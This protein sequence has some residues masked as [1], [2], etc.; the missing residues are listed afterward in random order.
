MTLRFITFIMAL[1]YVMFH[2]VSMLNCYFLSRL[3][4]LFKITYNRV[5]VIFANV[6]NVYGER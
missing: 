5:E 6:Y 2:N 4:K 3:Q 1:L